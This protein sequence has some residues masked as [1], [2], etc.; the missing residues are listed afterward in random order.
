MQ[1]MKWEHAD[2]VRVSK[3]SSSV[4]SQWLG[5]GS[6]TK[7]IKTIGKLEAAIYIE[8]ESGYSALWVAKN[9]G[10]KKPAKALVP[11]AQTTMQPSGG[12]LT[13]E[14][15]LEELGALLKSAPPEFLP[16]IA[17]NLSGWALAGGADQWLLA[18]TPLLAAE[19]TK[20][21]KQ[22]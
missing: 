7:I 16:A 22:A 12:Y 17:N 6:K 2:L 4:V 10:P 14:R 20:R 8:R 13:R 19:P 18:L 9:I 1:A 15:V 5:K 11:V 3:Q 21:P